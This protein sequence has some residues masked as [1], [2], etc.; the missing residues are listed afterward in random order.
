MDRNDRGIL[1]L[2]AKAVRDL[3]EQ[4]TALSREPGPPGKDGTPGKDGVDGKDGVGIRGLA[5][6]DGR[7]GAD[8]RDGRDGVD[9]K[10]GERGPM[11]PIP[12]HEWRGTQLRFQQTSGKWGK[13]TDL[14]GSAGKSGGG[15]FVGGSG[16]GGLFVS[17][18]GG[19]TMEGPLIVEN[20]GTAAA[21]V[22]VRAYG[23]SNSGAV[24][25]GNQARGTKEAPLP[26]LAG[27]AVFGIGA[28]PWDGAQWVE[29]S[30]GAVHIF[31]REDISPATQGSSFRIAVT[32]LGSNWEQRIH[33]VAFEVDGPGQGA[34]WRAKFS[35]SPLNTRSYFQ[36][37]TGN[38]TALGVLSGVDSGGA[39][40]INLFSGTS[41]LNSRYAQIANNTGIAA[42][43][44]FSGTSADAAL[45]A[46]PIRLEVEGGAALVLE[47]GGAVTSRVGPLGYGIGAGGTVTQA[48]SKSTAVTLNKP[49]GQITMHNARLGA[50][51]TVAFEVACD[52]LGPNDVVLVVLADYTAAGGSPS[53]Y[54]VSAFNALP[55]AQSFYVRLK[56]VSALPRS[57]GVKINFFI[58]KGAAS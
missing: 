43:R 12:K 34:R 17:K 3:R 7:D 41:P 23:F 20:T 33:A 19:D 26:P 11:G 51:N 10:D 13:W 53:H 55:N 25:H 44:V 46:Y 4:F 36:D 18:S 29:H 21:D 8:G 49:S 45:P 31:A 2:L 54:E 48:T 1:T 37:N 42:M 24:M 57:D 38:A 58:L 28:R 22:V 32:P 56:N 6:V 5:G 9:G 52:V 47:T 50:G 35:G 27:D 14:Q 39:S 40:S 15:V 30:I 16:S